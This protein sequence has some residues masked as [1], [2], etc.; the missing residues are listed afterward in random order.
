[1]RGVRP[2][3][4]LV[5][6]ALVAA[7]I[8]HVVIDVLG[9]YLLAHDTYDDI[10]HTSRAIVA[11]VALALALAGIAAGFRAALREAHGSPNALC[12]AIRRAIPRRTSAFVLGAMLASIAILCVMEGCDALLAG[13]AVDDIGDL[14]GGSIVLGG[15]TIAALSAIV[16]IATM[17]ALRRLAQ[18]QQIAGILAAFIRRS[19]TT[20]VPRTADRTL[21]NRLIFRT[22][23][24]CRRLAGRAPPLPFVAIS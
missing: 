13:H 24:M 10:D 14:F 12:N 4:V 9:D 17:R 1:V 8:G 23:R 21:T 15:T 16:S 22:H 6:V 11:I 19:F 20:A 3:G 5:S 7:L 18:A 2:A